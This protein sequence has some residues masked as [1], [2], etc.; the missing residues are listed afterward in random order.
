MLR[1]AFASDVL[2]SGGS[3]DEVQ[4]LLG[5]A[6]SRSTQPYLHPAPGRMREAVERVAS[7]RTKE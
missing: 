1:H 6:S 3:I 5:H 4:E 2:D 7:F